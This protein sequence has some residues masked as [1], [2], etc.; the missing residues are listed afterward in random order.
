MRRSLQMQ[1]ESSRGGFSLVREDGARFLRR[2][3][4]GFAN[5]GRTVDR[6]AVQLQNAVP[7]SHSGH[8]GGRRRIQL[9]DFDHV[10]PGQLFVPGDPQTRGRQRGGSLD[11]ILKS[12]SLL[13]DGPPK[14][15]QPR[16]WTAA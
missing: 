1:P 3:E 10:M 4:D 8:F 11:R 9:S 5:V 7:S 14:G 15:W 16:R 2:G 6:G 13:Q 12:A